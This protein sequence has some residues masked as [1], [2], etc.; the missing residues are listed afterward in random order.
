MK[1]NAQRT[2]LAKTGTGPI[3]IEPVSGTISLLNIASAMRI[4]VYPLDG[5]G[6]RLGPVISASKTSGGW[7]FPIGE[8]VTP[9]YLITVVR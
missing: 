2:S 3:L 4:D 7:Q 6:R 8:H 1:W 9:W 5:A